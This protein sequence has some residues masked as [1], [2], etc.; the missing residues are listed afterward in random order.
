[1]TLNDQLLYAAARDITLDDETFLFISRV[2][3]GAD[4]NTGDMPETVGDEPRQAP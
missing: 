2:L 4:P 3:R 1:M